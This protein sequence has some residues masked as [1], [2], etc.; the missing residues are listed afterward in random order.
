MASPHSHMEPSLGPPYL[1]VSPRATGQEQGLGK[2]T[3]LKTSFAAVLSEFCL[4]IYSHVFIYLYRLA[5]LG[6]ENCFQNRVGTDEIP[7]SNNMLTAKV[8]GC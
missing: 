5:Q 7:I 2:I 6:Y 4:W 8:T 3:A 1:P